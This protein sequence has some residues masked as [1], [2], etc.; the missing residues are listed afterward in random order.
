MTELPYP[1]SPMGKW[2]RNKERRMK[3]PAY[4]KAYEEVD[5]CTC[6]HRYLDHADHGGA[7]TKCVGC[8]MFP[9]E[10]KR[11]DAI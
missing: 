5:L 8:G 10:R 2:E 7:C 11:G 6:G 1:D 9:V 4:R 3:D